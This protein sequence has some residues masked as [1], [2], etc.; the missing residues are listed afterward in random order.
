M[1]GPKK[2]SHVPPG[3]LSYHSVP[4]HNTGDV[5]IFDATKLEAINTIQA[6]QSTIGCLALNSDATLL[7]TASE[8]GTVIRV[9][10]VPDGQNLF[11]FRRGSLPA[12]V[13]SMAFNATSTLLCVSSA[14]ETVHIFRLLNSGKGSL[15]TTPTSPEPPSY[16]RRWSSSSRER[17]GSPSSE[18]PQEGAIEESAPVLERK[19]SGF[20]GGFGSMLRQTS[21]DLGLGVAA[22]MGG[23]LPSSV[24]QALEPQRDFAHVKIPRVAIPNSTGPLRSIV[25]MSTNHPQLFVVTSEGAFGVF[26]IDLEKGGE[27]V[28]E[29]QYS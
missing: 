12:H 5:R 27:G 15:P 6:H 3:G 28:L 2:P 22:R 10:T 11:Q 25:A 9:F 24:T 21:R 4:A 29:Q 16:G 14:T 18:E 26:N 8:K 1:P 19:T 23:Y 13:F 20:I 17:S 7:A